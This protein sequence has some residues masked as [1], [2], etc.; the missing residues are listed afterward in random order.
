MTVPPRHYFVLGD[1]RRHSQ[2]SRLWGA[3]PHA[4]LA[5]R[6][7]ATYWSSAPPEIVAVAPPN[8]PAAFRRR[9]QAAARFLRATRWRRV[10]RPVC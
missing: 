7:V 4:T 1:N 5:G 9:L 10:L 8:V 6:V 3:L 2:D